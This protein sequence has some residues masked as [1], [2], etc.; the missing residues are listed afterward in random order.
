MRDVVVRLSYDVL[1]NFIRDVFLG[2]GVPEQDAD[3]SSEVLIASDI[4][5]IESHG[6]E[7]LKMYYDRLKNGQHKP[8]TDFEILRETPGTALV[9]GHA[10]VGMVIGHRSM[11][12]AIEKARVV[13]IGS[14]AVRNSTHFGI[15]GYYAR[16]AIHAGM[17]GMSF[18]NAR[19]S[20][21]PTFGVQPMLG[22]NPIA[23]GAPTDE[24]CPFLFDGA[25]S[26]TQRGK[27]EVLAR[28]EKPLPD[29]W[30]IN[31][32][33]ESVNNA[34]SILRDMTKEEAALLPLGGA[35][36]LLA[37]Y[38]GYGLATM[39]EILCASLQG[40]GF[41]HGLTGEGQNGH[42]QPFNIG[43]FF[44]AINIEAFCPL[45]EF[46]K[47]TGD[48]LRELRN[49]RKA[50]AQPRI[51]TAGEKEFENEKS[52]AS[53]GVPIGIVTQH[54]IKLMQQE[55]GLFQYQFPF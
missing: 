4:R 36:E 37:G 35:G 15:D 34:S 12:L 43:H 32:K 17:I 53:H 25:T 41:L 2:L 40:G 38:K 52:I 23:F 45:A 9:D 46:K 13:G 6:I 29:G 31:Q 21:A 42:L 22:T 14:V 11:A 30:V 24:D 19:P 8:V 55:L 54:E 33:N 47:T 10:G 20:I 50:P 16:M 3:I 18:T 39:V 27:I 48:I 1:Q 5:G 7:R 26:I 44:I 51:Y 49:S 28:K